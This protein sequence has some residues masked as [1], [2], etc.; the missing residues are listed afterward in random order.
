[1]SL[2]PRYD[3]LVRAMALSLG[4]DPAAV[5][6][7]G[8][9]LLDGFIVALDYEGTDSFG[10]VRFVTELG[11]PLPNREEEVHRTLLSANNYWTY[12][13][14]ATLGI[15]SETGCVVLCGRFHVDLIEGEQLGQVLRY[16]VQIA[17]M[18]Q[19]YVTDTIA[20]GLPVPIP[21][22]FRV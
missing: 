13:G 3:H 15:Q 14:G 16:F 9:L 17:R 11:V 18:W 22:A 20:S 4:Q 19:M 2:N 5:I 10:D 21:G 8:G 1:M 7:D 12:T 6:R